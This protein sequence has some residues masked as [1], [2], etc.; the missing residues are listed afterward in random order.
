[1]FPLK[2]VEM[3]ALGAVTWY[4]SLQQI[5]AHI[6]NSFLNIRVLLNQKQN[7]VLLL[8]LFAQTYLYSGRCVLHPYGSVVEHYISWSATSDFPALPC[9]RLPTRKT[10][11]V[12][13]RIPVWIVDLRNATRSACDTCHLE[14]TRTGRFPG[15][16]AWQHP[17]ILVESYPCAVVQ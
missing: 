9:L 14:Y 5:A 10:T 3:P 4:S 16:E 6:T 1:M 15:C 12:Q 11:Y 17:S 7:C 8:V 2:L 13:G